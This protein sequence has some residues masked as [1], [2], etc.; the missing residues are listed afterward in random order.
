MF[1]NY[2]LN[3]QKNQ[4][5]ADTTRSLRRKVRAGKKQKC[6][7]WQR[8]V[9]KKKRA[10]EKSNMKET[11]NSYHKYG[12]ESSDLIMSKISLVGQLPQLKLSWIKLSAS[13]MLSRG[14]LEWE[15]KWAGTNTNLP[16]PFKPEKDFITLHKRIR[17]CT[18]VGYFTLDRDI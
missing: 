15:W 5:Q 12:D 13:P 9:E 16:F 11:I 17:L 2:C 7:W 3:F 14:G 1:H 8:C 4:E 18:F 10:K 6:L